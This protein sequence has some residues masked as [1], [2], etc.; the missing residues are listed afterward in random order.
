MALKVELQQQDDGSVTLAYRFPSMESAVRF[1][2]ALPSTS[3][4]PSTIERPTALTQALAEKS[5][6]EK[7][8]SALLTLRGSISAKALM[9]IMKAPKHTITDEQLRSSLVDD[10]GTPISLAPSF[11]AISKRMTR[12]GMT[13]DDLY[14]TAKS[15]SGNK[16]VKWYKMKPSTVA[17]IESIENF[18]TGAPVAQ[19]TSPFDE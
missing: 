19:F 3:V 13:I 1:V 2:A 10:D 6:I 16:A 12:L 18:E 9:A 4:E 15:G 17:A 8:K 14:D 7:V 11:S 5:Q